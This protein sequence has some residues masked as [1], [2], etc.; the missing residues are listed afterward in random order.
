MSTDVTVLGF[1]CMLVALGKEKMASYGLPVKICMWV[2]QGLL[3]H[4]VSEETAKAALGI[5]CV[6]CWAPRALDSCL[7]LCLVPVTVLRA[8]HPGG[9]L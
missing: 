2:S 6:H 5:I 3:S 4:M 9:L 1:I 8:S 7:L